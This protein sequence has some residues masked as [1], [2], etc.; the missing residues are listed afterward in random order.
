[1]AEGF[2]EGAEVHGREGEGT[3]LG[4]IP[5]G[6]G[7]D[8]VAELGQLEVEGEEELGIAEGRHLPFKVG[9]PLRGE[10]V[11]APEVEG[12]LVMDPVPLTDRSGDNPVVVAP[13][14]TVLEEHGFGRIALAT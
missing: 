7:R 11:E 13:V 3:V 5:R 2:V 8:R 10:G 6:V 4:E 1:M 12:G 14:R 9:P